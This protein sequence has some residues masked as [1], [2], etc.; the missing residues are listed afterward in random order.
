MSV[1][2]DP[3]LVRSPQGGV[4]VMG[5]HADVCAALERALAAAGFQVVPPADAAEAGVLDSLRPVALVLQSTPGPGTGT[6]PDSGTPARNREPTV[7][8][9]GDLVVDPHR[10]TVRRGVHPIELGVREFDALV[11]LLRNTP[12]VVTKQVLLE[13]VWNYGGYDPNV[14]EV[15][16]CGLRRKLESHGPRVIQTVRGLGYVARATP[17][18]PG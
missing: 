8:E 2:R 15:A 14:V 1:Q 9:L 6:G 3:E 13:T 16:I 5:P 12:W 17:S 10:R 18:S 7:L 11:V 4:L